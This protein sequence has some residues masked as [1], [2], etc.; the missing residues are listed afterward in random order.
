[1]SY[2][3]IVLE[4]FLAKFFRGV[5]SFGALGIFKMIH[6]TPN[7]GNIVISGKIRAVTVSNNIIV[8]FRSF[9]FS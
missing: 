3:S 5:L 9:S 6:I 7:S 1:M 2:L 8:V 4:F